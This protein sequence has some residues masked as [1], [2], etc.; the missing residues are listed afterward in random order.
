MSNFLSSCFLFFF[1]ILT[2]FSSDFLFLSL[3][4]G[5]IT[6]AVIIMFIP[7]YSF[8][9]IR[10]L[11]LLCSIV[12]FIVSLFFLINLNIFDI[13]YQY[14][15]HVDWLSFLNIYVSFGLDGISLLFIILTTFLI[16][17]CILSSWEIIKYNI[18]MYYIIFLITESLLIL[19]F[20]S[21]DLILF[22]IFFESILIPMF[23]II[24]IWGS[25]SR[26]IH[27]S[28]QF[29]IYTLLGSIFMLISLIFLNLNI[30]TTDI[31]F[32]K[33]HDISLYRQL[34]LWLAFFASF[35]VKIP[36]FPFHIW[37][38]EA[39]VEAPTA[40]SVLLAGILLKLG[41]YGFLR[42]SIPLL[43]E[44][45]VYFLP[46]IYSLS[47]IAII[48]ASMTTIRQIDLKKIIAYSS[49]VH[50][51]FAL[52][53]LF[54]FNF[55]SIAGSYFL[56]LSHGIVSGGL[57]LCVGVLYDRYH[58]RLLKYYNGLNMF[59][60][61]FSICFLLLT[62]SN[63]SFPGTISFIGEFLV[64]I[65]VFQ[66]NTFVIFFGSLSLILGGVYAFWLYNRVFFGSIQWLYIQKFS[67]LNLREFLILFPLIILIIS[68]GIYSDRYFQLF[69]VPLCNLVYLNFYYLF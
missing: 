55:Q 2:Y 17:L 59:M 67:D 45:S 14:V 5:P 23:F 6:G 3:I 47:I 38:P 28:Y 57:F 36:M 10:Y 35:A 25:R 27:A 30:G 9:A 58:T 56:M 20:S 50:M 52:L 60:P 19:V 40:G 66:F 24:G 16:V 13:G 42:F 64:I 22:Y 34:F 32:L 7:Q 51:N 31:Q 37:L 11:A 65:G 68:G 61:I 8:Y 49:I 63:V 29:F 4:L 48:Y 53:G 69:F 62:L 26:R 41:S 46:L 1:N 21:L 15:I 33:Y 54:T 39:H 43:T 12:V 18:K 44:A